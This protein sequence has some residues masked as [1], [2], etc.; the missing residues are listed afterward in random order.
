MPA[1]GCIQRRWPQS[2]QIRRSVGVVDMVISFAIRSKA[3]NS[4]RQIVYRCRRLARHEAASREYGAGFC[5][6]GR[7]PSPR[8]GLMEFEYVGW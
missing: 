4:G 8:R 7:P 2:I 3:A 5:T 1:S 6:D